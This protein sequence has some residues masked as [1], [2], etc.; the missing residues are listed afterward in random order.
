M[1]S[2]ALGG[3]LVELRQVI[4]IRQNANGANITHLEGGSLGRGINLGNFEGEDCSPPSSGG[5]RPAASL[6]NG[7]DVPGA[8][9]VSL[10]KNGP[11]LSFMIC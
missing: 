5:A 7:M 2:D 8:V 3:L 10:I 9:D 6:F 11:C 4:Q 1:N